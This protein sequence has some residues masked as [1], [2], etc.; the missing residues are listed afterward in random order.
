MAERTIFDPAWLYNA[1]GRAELVTSGDR[2][3]QLLQEGWFTPD[4]LKEHGIETH[5]EQA[6]QE[7]IQTIYG[8]AVQEMSQRTTQHGGQLRQIEE[9]VLQLPTLV[10]SGQQTQVQLLDTLGSIQQELLA[11]HDANQKLHARLVAVET[12][13]A[14]APEKA[15]ESRQPQPAAGGRPR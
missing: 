7:V 5:P 12:A 3:R 13:I 9:T 1:A 4:K 15:P 6:Q 14:P 8:P 2:Y 10:E 11:A